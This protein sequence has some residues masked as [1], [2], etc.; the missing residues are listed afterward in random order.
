MK[1]N[2]FFGVA[3][4]CGLLAFPSCGSD[5]DPILGGSGNS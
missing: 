5:D 1:K 2:Y 4:L 3:A